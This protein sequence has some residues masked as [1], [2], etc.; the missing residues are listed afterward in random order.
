[1]KC[2]ECNSTHILRIPW[3]KQVGERL[4]NAYG[5]DQMPEVGEWD[6]SLP[7]QVHRMLAL[8]P[9]FTSLPKILEFPGSCLIHPFIQQRQKSV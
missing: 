3:D 4:P 9:I 1:M 2:P 8:D 7:F 5:P 6:E